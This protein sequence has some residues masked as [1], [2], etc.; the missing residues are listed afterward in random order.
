VEITFDCILGKS[1][2]KPLVIKNDTPMESVN[3]NLV[4][5]EDNKD[6]Y[7]VAKDIFG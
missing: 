1:K 7:D 6:L 3:E 2:S 4:E 5:K